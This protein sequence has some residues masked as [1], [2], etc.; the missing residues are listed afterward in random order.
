MSVSNLTSSKSNMHILGNRSSEEF[1]FLR[2]P[3]PKLYMSYSFENHQSPI[4][5]H[6]KVTNRKFTNIER[7]LTN[8]FQYSKLAK[9]KNKNSV[10]QKKKINEL[11]AFQ[12]SI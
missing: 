11:Y 5:K 6:S 4:E 12:S 9:T 10:I 2:K 3:F 8:I 7:K 1:H